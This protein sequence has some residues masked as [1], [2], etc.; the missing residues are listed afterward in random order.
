MAAIAEPLPDGL[1]I[2]MPVYNEIERIERALDATLAVNLPCPF[3][4]LPSPTDR[5]YQCFQV[6]V[7]APFARGPGA[8]FVSPFR[9]MSIRLRP[10]RTLNDLPSAVAPVKRTVPKSASMGT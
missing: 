1:S 4:P 2:L 5:A 7:K 3:E 6:T 10:F 8:A 9:T